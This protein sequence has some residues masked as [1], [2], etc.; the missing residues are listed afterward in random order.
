MSRTDFGLA[1]SLLPSTSWEA[2]E[3]K[4]LSSLRKTSKKQEDTSDSKP[5]SDNGQSQQVSTNPESNTWSD[6]DISTSEPIL[7]KV[8]FDQIKFYK[9]KKKKSIFH[10]L[11]MS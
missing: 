10:L 3:F 5:E 7:K 9:K 2:E 6:S 11:N 4:D 1:E 8:K